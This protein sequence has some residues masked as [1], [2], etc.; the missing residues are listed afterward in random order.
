M[1]TYSCTDQPI[2]IH[3]LYTPLLP[4]HFYRLPIDVM[5]ATSEGVSNRAKGPAGARIRFRTD[6]VHVSVRITLDTNQID[7]AIP[8][9]G[10]AGAPVYIGHGQSPRYAGLACPHNYA[11]KTSG[12][13]F[14]KAADMEDITI[15]LPRN[16]VVASVE[17][18]LDDDARLEAPTPYAIRTPIVFYGSSITEGGCASRATNAYTALLAK[19]LDADYLNL[20]FSGAA[21]GEPVLAE[22]IAGLEMSAFI[23]DYDHNAPSPEHLQATHEPFF[24]IIRKAQPTLPILML[25]KPDFD[26]HP[27][28]AAARRDIVR[29]TYQHA[30]E[31]GD[32]HVAFIDGETF[33]GPKDRIDCTIEGCHPNDLGF[34]RM[35]QTIYPVLKSMLASL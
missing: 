1:K 28:D 24:Q 9:S 34:M 18:S 3:G 12:L 21:K 17:I 31:A 32:G 22:Y 2:E 33:F 11:D 27:A 7:W 25:T 5:D 30:V 20:G 29:Q 23:Y 8:L 4:Q 10:S 13:T 19:W 14:T 15:F 26:A 35:A 16:E 6:S